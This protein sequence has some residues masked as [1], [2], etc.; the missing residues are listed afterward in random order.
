M[1]AAIPIVL[2]ALLAGGSVSEQQYASWAA[3]PTPKSWRLG[4]MWAFVLLDKKGEIL[5]SMT[6]RFTDQKAVSCLAGNWSR[7]ETIRQRGAGAG[8]FSLLGRPLSYS[9]EGS[10]L[11]VGANDV[12]DGYEEL[13]GELKD[14]GVTGQ[15]IALSIGMRESLGSFYGVPIEN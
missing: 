2:G 14:N 10:A 4:Q 15:Y 7:V 6:V 9:L 13:V 11:T 1:R 8:P 12:C 5:G 3:K